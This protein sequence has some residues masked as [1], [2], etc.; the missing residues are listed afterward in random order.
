MRTCL[1]V[2]DLRNDIIRRVEEMSGQ[3]L[4]ACY[5]CGNC[6]AGCP[7]AG[8]M[9]LLPN[10]IIRLLQLGRVQEVL[11]SKAIWY[12]AACLTCE[13]RCPK[14]I[15]VARITEAL[16]TLAMEKGIRFIDIEELPPET[17]ADLPQQACIGGFRKYNI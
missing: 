10:Q 2:N 3:D 7:A 8:A 13:A 4:M 12:C 9:D 11:H 6:S 1:N 14:G 16:R 17:L 15:D 5:Q